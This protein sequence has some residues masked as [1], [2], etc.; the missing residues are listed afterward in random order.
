MEAELNKRT[1][2]LIA[3]RVTTRFREKDKHPELVNSKEAASILSLSEAHVRRLA[4]QGRLPHVKQGDC[5]Q[6]RLL[7]F[8]DALVSSY[9]R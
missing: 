7:F 1:I 5:K 2:D 9:I 4:R 6:G 8:R 3:D